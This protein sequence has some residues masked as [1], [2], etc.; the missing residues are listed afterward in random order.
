MAKRTR[1]TLSR[2]EALKGLGLAAAGVT[3]GCGGADPEGEGPS[4]EGFE[5]VRS[6]IDT[7]VVLIMENRSFDH[8]FGALT[9]EEGR[10]DV[11]G[12]TADIANPH[13][14]GS[15]VPVFHTEV[16]CLAD[17]PHSWNSSHAQF[18]EGANDGFVREFAAR[19]PEVAHEAMGYLNRADLPA[20]YAL[21]DAYTLC[22]HWYSS[23]MTS[24]QPNRF[25]FHCGQSGGYTNNDVQVDQDYPSVYT[26]AA[27]KGLTWGAYYANLPGILLVPDRKA[28]D[29]QIQNLDAFF[30]AA[31]AGT[32]PNVVL[33]E[34]PY[35]EAD[36]HPP[37]HPTAGQLYIAQIYEALANSP[38]WERIA[39]FVTYDEHGGF[40]DHVPPPT[41]PDDRA[42]EGFD[43]LGFRVPGLVI[44]PWVK[45]GHVS[46]VVY[47]HTSALAFLEKLFEL[48]PLTKRSAA[49]D[50]MLDC[51]DLDA[52]AAGLP[53]Q[54]VVLDPIEA[55]PAELFRPECVTDGNDLRWTDGA[56]GQP[57]AEAVVRTHFRGTRF[58]VFER[59]REI[60]GELLDRALER[61]LLVR[62]PKG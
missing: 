48:E 29:M 10:T 51:F 46:H 12:L 15:M 3:A 61:G 32:L 16:D 13:P 53:L 5:L 49:A 60:H 8:Y 40:H 17:P 27:E 31:E 34:P 30:A 28:G 57:E 21:S 2:R 26:R 20:L 35:G 4:L 19:E 18:N 9:L 38:Q 33:V 37:A 14:D 24:T 22:D 45:P 47:D 59:S 25:Y 36:D 62:P 43:Q 1:T 7:V 52:M 39:F 41:A 50:P 6:R 56:T 58:D 11:E 44:G 54:P 42:S 55:D 23:L